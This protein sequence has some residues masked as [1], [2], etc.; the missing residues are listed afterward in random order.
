MLT[1]PVGLIVGRFQMFHN[2]HKQMIQCAL[3]A[4]DTVLLLIGS[5][6]KEN[7]KTNPFSYLRRLYIIKKVFGEEVY[8]GR[9]VIQ[10]LPDI[11]IGNN[12]QWGE[13]VLNTAREVYGFKPQVMISG[14]EE[15]REAWFNDEVKELFIPKTCDISATTLREAMIRDDRVFWQKYVPKVIWDEYEDLRRLLIAAQENAKTASV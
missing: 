3:D 8:S 5:S 2:G 15:R 1:Y 14:K 13:Y 7:T 11:G 4:C 12:Q 9:L 10:P 6:Q